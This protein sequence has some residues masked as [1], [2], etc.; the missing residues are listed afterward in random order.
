MD[1]APPFLGARVSFDFV[2]VAAK[3]PEIFHALGVTLFVWIVS[4][5]GAG[6]LGFLV[7]V[8]RRFGPRWLGLALGGYVE[9]FR[10]TPFL[11]Q[12]FLLALFYWGLV[13]ICGW[14]G[15]LGEARLS[16]LKFAGA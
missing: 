9:I 3:L 13:E 14:L 15:R 1:R 11:I 2:L 5:I 7:A 16:R 12:L 4:L 10:G 6:F 8:G